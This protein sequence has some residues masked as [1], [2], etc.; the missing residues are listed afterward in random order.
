MEFFI[1]TD[2]IA[3]NMTNILNFSDWS[4]NEGRDSDLYHWMPAIKITNL[5]HRDLIQA[6]WPHTIDG[7]NYKGT[8]MTRNKGLDYPYD[9]RITFDQNKLYSNHKIIPIDGELIY[10][11]KFTGYEVKDR[12]PLKF[13]PDNSFIKM[14]PHGIH[15]TILAEEFVI[16]DIKNAHK[17]IKKIEIFQSRIDTEESPDEWETELLKGYADK[18]NIS[19]NINLARRL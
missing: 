9:I 18:W 1:L 19:M 12:D 15:N 17:N 6:Y 3:E 11:R 10:N 7:K 4:L 8:S 16:G 13:S 2:H 14:M 5:F